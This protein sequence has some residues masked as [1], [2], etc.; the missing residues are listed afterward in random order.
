MV[1]GDT[2]VEGGRRP[3]CQEVPCRSESGG[4]AY[5]AKQYDDDNYVLLTVHCL[6]ARLPRV[7]PDMLRRRFASLSCRPCE[8]ILSLL[9]FMYCKVRWCDTHHATQVSYDSS[10]SGGMILIIPLRRRMTFRVGVQE[11][12]VCIHCLLHARLLTQTIAVRHRGARSK[13]HYTDFTKLT[14]GPL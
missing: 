9:T 4:I 11:V 13:R 6:D 3:I 12:E 10:S 1:R 14:L 5:C 2:N 7:C 8:A